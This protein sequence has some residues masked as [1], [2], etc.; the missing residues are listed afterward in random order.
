MNVVK[1]WK[2]IAYLYIVNH[3]P[4]CIYYPLFRYHHQQH[5]EKFKK[6]CSAKGILLPDNLSL[7][8]YHK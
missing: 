3:L 6:K 4:D 5:L 7:K 1:K 8:N 2:M